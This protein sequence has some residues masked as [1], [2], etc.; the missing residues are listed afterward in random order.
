MENQYY[1]IRVKHSPKLFIHHLHFTKGQSTYNIGVMNINTVLMDRQ[2]PAN[3]IKHYIEG[4]LQKPDTYF[5]L[6]PV[7]EWIKN[8]V[9]EKF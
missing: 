8:R 3:A 2:I 7:N 5:E 1:L 9:I 6:Y 4:F